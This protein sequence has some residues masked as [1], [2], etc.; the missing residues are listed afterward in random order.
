MKEKIHNKT[1][2]WLKYPEHWR[3]DELIFNI[4]LSFAIKLVFKLSGCVFEYDARSD[5]TIHGWL[6]RLEVDVP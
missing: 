6:A 3:E 1:I 4:V 5:R 2:K